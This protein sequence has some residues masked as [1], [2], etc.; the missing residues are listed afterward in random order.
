MCR[1]VDNVIAGLPVES[2][3]RFLQGVTAVAAGVGA[4]L[5]GV[6]ASAA[7]DAA[8][9]LAR[10]SS[11]SHT[12]LVL[13][14]TGGGPV[15]LDGSRKGMST[16]VVYADR[17]YLVDLGHAAQAQ[18]MLAGLA[19]EG[20]GGQLLSRVRGI[21]ITHMHSDH[22]VEWPAVWSTGTLNRSSSI[23]DPI[24]VFG[25]GNRGT[26][27]RVFP[28]QR[29]APAVVNPDDPT[30][31]IRAMTGYLEQAFAQDLNDRMRDSNMTPPSRVFDVNDID[32]SSVWTIDDTGVPPRLAAPLQIWE[33]GEVRITATLVDHHPTAPAFAFRFDT[34]DGSVV[35]SGDTRPSDNLIDL[36]RGADYLVHEVI[37]PA[38]AD[39]LA[40]SLPPN[41]GIPLREHLLE[42]HT[43][44]E[45]V[46]RDVAEP[47]GVANLV[48]SHI[49]PGNADRKNLQAAQ[50]GFKGRLIVGQDLMEL[51]V[52]S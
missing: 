19:G 3:R 9:V 2:R 43:T 35:I 46:G 47:A 6:P 16:A 33:D 18:L 15:L 4:G 45:Q 31:G 21:F 52:S 12:R 23:A 51:A 48:L 34:P 38:F 44:I 32:I 29:P 7:A 11:N 36:A 24:R 26:L 25:P 42:S 5:L 41:I 37:D 50:R 14:G 17:V 13:L 28:P 10:G 49:V 40:A 20:F 27:P 8:P 1:D 22:T 30:P 39:A